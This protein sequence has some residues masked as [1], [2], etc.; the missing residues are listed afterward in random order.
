MQAVQAMETEDDEFVSARQF[1]ALGAQLLKRAPSLAAADDH[2]RFLA[3]FCAN[4]R[5]CCPLRSCFAA[6]AR[7]KENLSICCGISCP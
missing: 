7:R 3:L 6:R 2:W 5:V 1:V 4:P